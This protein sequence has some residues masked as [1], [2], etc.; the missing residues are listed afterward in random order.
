MFVRVDKVVSTW[1][2]RPRWLSRYCW[3]FM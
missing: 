3:L 2:S 1:S